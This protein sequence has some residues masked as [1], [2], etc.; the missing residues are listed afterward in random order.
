MRNSFHS[1]VD[2]ALEVS[3]LDRTPRDDRF[4]VLVE[5]FERAVDALEE[6][7]DKRIST[8]ADAERVLRAAQLVNAPLT[9]A[10]AD[11]SLLRIHRGATER[12]RGGHC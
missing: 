12:K 6:R 11:Q 7:F 2:I 8:M 4:D 5:E 10:L 1:V 3:R 9:R